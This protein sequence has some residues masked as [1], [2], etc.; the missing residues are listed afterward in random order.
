[1]PDIMRRHVLTVP[2]L[3]ALGAPRRSQAASPET[4]NAPGITNTEIKF[5]QTLPYSG[6][7]S[8]YG[9]LGRVEAA[10]FRALNQAGGING[11]KISVVSLDDGFSP[12]KAVEQ[13]RR[14]EHLQVGRNR[15][16]GASDTGA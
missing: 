2:A 14:L 9:Q 5:G 4:R 7:A 8:A 11:R 15:S 3:L 12:P 1:M 6:P 10:Y 16:M 13:V